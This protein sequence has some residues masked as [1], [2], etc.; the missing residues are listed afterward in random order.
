[1]SPGHLLAACCFLV[2]AGMRAVEGSWVWAGVFALAA[3]AQV[4]LGAR[5]RSAPG[6]Q[7][8]ARPRQAST[9]RLLTVSSCVLSAVLLVVQ[10]ALGLVAAVVALYCLRAARTAVRA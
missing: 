1:M 2:L 5:F 3:L 6:A 9:W 4:V 8:E 10:P 7:G